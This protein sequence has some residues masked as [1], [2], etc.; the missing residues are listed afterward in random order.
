MIG[1]RKNNI[2]VYVIR[3]PF[4]EIKKL[5]LIRYM[6]DQVYVLGMAMLAASP[7]RITESITVGRVPKAPAQ[8]LCRR[9]MAASIISGW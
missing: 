7:S 9:P 6:S 8:L 4:R 5:A 3:D 2:Y 1:L